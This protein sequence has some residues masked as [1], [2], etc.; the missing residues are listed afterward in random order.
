MKR[1]RAFTLIELLVVIAIIAILAA[2]L[3]PVFA[4]ARVA[5]KKASGIS[6]SKQLGLAFAMYANDNEDRMP[7]A[8]GRTWAGTHLWGFM[9]S[10]PAGKVVGWESAN[11]VQ[12]SN[13]LWA[14]TIEP[15]IKNREIYTLA[16]QTKG[17]LF[18]G[19]QF[20]PTPAGDW[21]VGITMNGLMHQLPQSAIVSPSHAVI[22]WPG[23]GID[24][25][26]NR[27][28]SNPSL[29]CE[30]AA[31]PCMFQAG[32]NPNGT[33]NQASDTFF[34]GPSNTFW[35]Y[36]RTTPFM[37]AD[38]SV[39]AQR[40]GNTIAPAEEDINDPTAGYT[41]PFSQVS[42]SGGGPFSYWACGTRFEN[43]YHCF[44]RPDKEQ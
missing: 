2:I 40:I 34:P 27:A 3:F 9:H 21:Y 12:A 24:S 18:D 39:K 7:L 32:A 41:D 22:A 14:I 43:A 30:N 16:G 13:Q 11:A 6:A 28:G 4:Q 31:N 44:F 15:Y 8:Q 5:A 36:S 37:R 42:A 35:V 17:L 33:T 19:D 1:L 38:S 25:G 10:I 20:N 29:I 26:Q 23:T